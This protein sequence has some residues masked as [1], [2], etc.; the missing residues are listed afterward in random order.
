MCCLPVKQNPNRFAWLHTTA[1]YS[2]QLGPDEVL[3]L[4]G[5]MR[6]EFGAG[7]GGN[8]SS[9]CRGLGVH[10]P[11]GV[12]VFH[13]IKLLESLSGSTYITLS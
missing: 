7:E 10:G 13:V 2:D 8:A 11:V 3:A 9:G 5:F 1:Y 12:D 4:F 6:S